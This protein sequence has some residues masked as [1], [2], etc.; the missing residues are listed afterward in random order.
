MKDAIKIIATD[1]LDS[2][3]AL[4][5]GWRVAIVALVAIALVS[6]LK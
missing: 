5:N 2:F 1:V 3:N 4:P 6:I